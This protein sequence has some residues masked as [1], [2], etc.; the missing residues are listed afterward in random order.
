MCVLCREPAHR[1]SNVD[2]KHIWVAVAVGCTQKTHMGDPR[3]KSAVGPT[4]A[5]PHGGCVGGFLGQPPCGMHTEI[6]HR[7]PKGYMC[8]GP[9]QFCCFCSSIDTWDF[10]CISGY[11]SWQKCLDDSAVWCWVVQW[12]TGGWVQRTAGL[13]C[14]MMQR[15]LPLLEWEAL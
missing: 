1:S 15:E 10:Q 12:W 11:F 8:S 3:S 14:S 5:I 13:C 6:S 7:E 4:W 9:K 2:P